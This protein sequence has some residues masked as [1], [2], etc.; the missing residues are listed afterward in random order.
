MWYI[1]QGALKPNTVKRPYLKG[2]VSLILLSE[3]RPNQE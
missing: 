2:P 1:V 3:I